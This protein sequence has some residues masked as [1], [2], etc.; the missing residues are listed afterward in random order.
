MPRDKAVKDI[1]QKNELEE[2]INKCKVCHV[3]MID[4]NNFPY[5]LGFNFGYQDE[6]IYIH[7]SQEG[8]KIDVLKNNNNVCVYFDADLDLFARHEKVACSWRMRYRSVLVNG[9]AEFVNDFDEKV[10]AL[11]IFMKNYSDL[12]FNYSKPA[13]NNVNIIKIKVDSWTGRSFEY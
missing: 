8:R 12:E 1:L 9:K 2:V 5:V 3:G 13:I 7:T 10:E 4:E 11:N 6:M